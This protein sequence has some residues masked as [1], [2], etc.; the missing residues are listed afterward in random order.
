M[1]PGLPTN[2][3][4]DRKEWRVWNKLKKAVFAPMRNPRIRMAV[5]VNPGDLRS[6]RAE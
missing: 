3:T 4:E 5:T 1:K 2:L 6:I